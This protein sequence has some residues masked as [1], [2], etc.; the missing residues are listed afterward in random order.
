MRRYR[1]DREIP[2]SVAA[3]SMPSLLTTASWFSVNVTLG[4]PSVRPS[5]RT[6]ASPSRTR[7]AIR[8]R[9]N[10]A[11]CSALHKADYAEF[12]IMLSSTAGAQ[13]SW[14]FFS[15]RTPHNPV[16]RSDAV[17]SRSCRLNRIAR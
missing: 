2:N 13:V 7:S 5:A 1:V 6:R 10:S 12:E 16:S 17:K 14:A 15:C 11:M 3:P 8:A 9:S 4:R